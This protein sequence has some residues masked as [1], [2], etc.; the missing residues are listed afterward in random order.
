M[1][2]ELD[3]LL[4][5]DD[6]DTRANLCDILELDG[7][8]ITVVASAGEARQVTESRRFCIVILDRNLPDGTA[9]ELL[10][11]LKRQLPAAMVIVVT[12]YADMDS[13][14]A[15]FRRGASD[16]ILK[17]INPEALR[18][19]LRRIIRQRQTESHLQQEQEFAEQVLQ[20]AEAVILV[21]DLQGHI[22]R[23]NPFFERITGWELSELSGRDWFESCIPASDR[24]RIRDVFVATARGNH[25]TGVINAVRC[26]NGTERQ[27]R[28]SNTVLR[29]DEHEPTAVLAVGVDVT[30][31]LA[32]QRRAAQA[33]RLAAIGQTMTA[34]AHE[35]RN[36]LQRIQAGLELL[37]L[38]LPDRMETRRDLDSV[39]RAAHDLNALM[40]EVRLFAAPI[41]LHLEEA[42][43][44]E[45]AECSWRHLESVR[46]ERQAQL[47]VTSSAESSV[48]QGDVVRL[49]QVFRNL[50]ENSL[51]ACD[52]PV[53][54]QVELA[55]PMEIEG[56]SM[57][58]VTVADNG[59]GLT[60]E[61]RNQ[62]FEPFYTTK[63]GGTG[64]GMSITQ[65]VIHAHRGNIM[66]AEASDQHSG[67]KFVIHLPTELR[68][69]CYER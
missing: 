37:S 69:Q 54:I 43:L 19:S 40:E 21:L 58:E 10:P 4:V 18:N 26:K 64:L 42:E 56:V 8:R 29:N 6:P 27:I 2:D 61:Q 24:D 14:I 11:D 44:H 31:Y 25:T 33:Q 5:E 59:P 53:Q 60:P 34:L 23:F 63:S 15:A 13:T 45:I 30:G 3:I 67:A 66:V 36:A 48:I 20:T 12:G 32:A 52:D 16:Y 57:I 49:E 50:F 47:E 46:Q 1:K 39:Q 17:P 41:R 55:G 51:A 62:I 38:D 7:H 9:E 68:D 22:V 35:S 65:R 28:W